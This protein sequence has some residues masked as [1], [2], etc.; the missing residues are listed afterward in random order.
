MVKRDREY[1]KIENITLICYVIG[2]ALVCIIK[3]IPFI[4]LTIM[5]YP[6]SL[7]PTDKNKW[8]GRNATPGKE[9]K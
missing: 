3:F 5:A 2:L 9:R 1:K 4:F 8:S 7:C 6:I